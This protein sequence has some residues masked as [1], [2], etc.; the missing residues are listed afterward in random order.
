MNIV[1][2]KGR[3][4]RPYEAL[5]TLYL[6]KKVLNSTQYWIDNLNKITSVFLSFSYNNNFLN[7]TKIKF[8]N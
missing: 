1:I 3:G 2:K 8:F 4:N 6:L 7:I 5:A